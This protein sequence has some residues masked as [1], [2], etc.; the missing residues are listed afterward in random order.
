[1]DA[2]LVQAFLVMPRGFDSWYVPDLVGLE[3]DL[4]GSMSALLK[5]HQAAA[6]TL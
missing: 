4:V 5:L 2:S 6:E 1:M 3:L